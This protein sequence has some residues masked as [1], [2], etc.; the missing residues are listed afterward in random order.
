MRPCLL[1]HHPIVQGAIWNLALP[2]PACSV[3]CVTAALATQA[4]PLSPA[5]LGHIAVWLS[6][7]LLPPETWRALR[8]SVA[9]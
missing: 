3:P 2:G 1:C 8:A 7:I 9:P 6:A 5:K 4:V